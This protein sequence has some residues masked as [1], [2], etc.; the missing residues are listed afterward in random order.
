MLGGNL[1][2]L[3]YGDVYVMRNPKD[4]YSHDAAQLVYNKLIADTSKYDLSN[5]VTVRNQK[6][7]FHL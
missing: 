5:S 3:L 7:L 4:R 2:S 6:V 1:G